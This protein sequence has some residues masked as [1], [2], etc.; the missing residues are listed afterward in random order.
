MKR[1]FA[2]ES[3]GGPLSRIEDLLLMYLVAF[4]KEKE[5]RICGNLSCFVVILSN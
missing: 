3:S 2:F 4:G 1:L 5:G